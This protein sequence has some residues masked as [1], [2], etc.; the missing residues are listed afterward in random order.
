MKKMI[1]KIK[2]ESY[3][4]FL[5]YYN[6]YDNSSWVYKWVNKCIKSICNDEGYHP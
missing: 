2:V 3:T 4:K 5:L 6:I 1:A